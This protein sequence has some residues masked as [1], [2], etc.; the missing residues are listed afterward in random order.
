[1]KSPGYA[2]WVR[3]KVVQNR[4]CNDIGR[5]VFQQLTGENESLCL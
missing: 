2:P 4:N 5:M 3:A 1:L